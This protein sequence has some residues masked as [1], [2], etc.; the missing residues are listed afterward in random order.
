MGTRIRNIIPNPFTE[1]EMREMYHVRGMSQ[2]DMALEASV[3]LGHP[4]A[5][6]SVSAWMKKHNINTRTNSQ[7]LRLCAITKPGYVSERL[8]RIKRIRKLRKVERNGTR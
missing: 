4:V 8:E 5:Q 2:R 3:L 7:A 6:G 1:T